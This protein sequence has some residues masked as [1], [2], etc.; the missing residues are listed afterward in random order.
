MTTLL[1]HHVQTLRL[2]PDAPWPGKM[3][4]VR[5]MI[6]TW[7]AEQRVKLVSKTPRHHQAA[8]GFSWV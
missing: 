1:R 6:R 7:R 5:E 4:D 8:Q 2:K 3:R